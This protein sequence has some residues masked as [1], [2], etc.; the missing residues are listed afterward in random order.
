MSVLALAPS[1]GASLA[2]KATGFEMVLVIM[3]L[4]CVCTLGA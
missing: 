2:W 1:G 3:G 4:A